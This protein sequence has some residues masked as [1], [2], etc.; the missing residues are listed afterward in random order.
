MPFSVSKAAPSLY[1]AHSCPWQ[2]I[3]T[4][5]NGAH[6]NEK[7]ENSLSSWLEIDGTDIHEKSYQEEAYDDHAEPKAVPN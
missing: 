6:S 2:K 5:H 1:F 4:V 3:E 7:S